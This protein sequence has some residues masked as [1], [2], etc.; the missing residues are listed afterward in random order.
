MDVAEATV[1]GHQ[2]RAIQ[3]MQANSLPEVDRM[4]DKLKFV[5][6]MPQRSLS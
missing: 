5:H 2:S 6:D 4:A 3:K 1:K